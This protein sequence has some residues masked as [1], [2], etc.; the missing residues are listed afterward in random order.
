MRLADLTPATTWRAFFLVAVLVATVSTAGAQ[1]GRASRPPLMQFGQPNSAEAKAALEQL[2]RQGIASDY[3][4]ELEVRIMPRRG[5]ERRVAGR[6]WGGRNEIGPLTRVSLG[7]AGASE[8]RLLIQNGRDSAV[9]RWTPGAKTERLGVESWF[10]PLIA[11]TELTAFDLQRPYVYWDNFSYEGVTRFRGRPAHIM[12]L[13]P[14]PAFAA[15]H[16]NVSG[17]RVHLDTQF[18]ALVQTELLGRNGTVL[19][20]LTLLD[21]KKI[22]DQW[23][24]KTFDIRDE[25][26]RNK[27]RIGVT[28]AA[29]DLDLAAT[30][31]EPAMLEE[32]VQAPRDTKLVRID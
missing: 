22:G 24:P 16:P 3:F 14:P 15:S 13:Q 10:E 32:P 19:K 25:L 17:V 6:L 7:E 23:I 2:R 28:A 11:A 8:R 20:T 31:F 27:T 30:L 5:E 4:L 29:L 21:L 1:S 26:T 9:W 12:V 18:N